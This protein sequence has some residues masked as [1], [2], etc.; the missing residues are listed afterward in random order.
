MIDLIRDYLVANTTAETFETQEEAFHLMETF[1]IDNYDDSY[2]NIIMQY[3]NSDP[4]SVTDQVLALTKTLT[5]DI[6]KNHTVKLNDEATQDNV[7]TILNGIYTLQDYSN[8]TELEDIANMGYSSEETLAEFLA[9]TCPESVENLLTVIDSASTSLI[10]R[11]VEINSISETFITKGP[12]HMA[13]VFK[14]R[15]YFE[16]LEVETVMYKLLNEGLLVGLP[17]HV[18]IDLMGTNVINAL[19]DDE[20]ARELVAA[21]LASEE[22]HSLP[23]PVALKDLSYFINDAGRLTKL[24]LKIKDIIQKFEVYISL[25][26]DE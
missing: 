16:F 17:H 9:V 14:L 10:K 13:T 24:L 22:G 7:N 23:E 26:E 15:K 21:A 3:D 25:K 8:G 5:L 11:I 1:G 6:L 18:Y 20:L 4:I 2:V 12:E 19:D